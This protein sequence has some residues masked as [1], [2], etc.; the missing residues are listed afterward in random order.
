LLFA[1][2]RRLVPSD[3]FPL[4]RY[5]FVALAALAFLLAGSLLVGLLSK[6]LFLG[7]S[8]GLF[9]IIAWYLVL[10]PGDR[11]R[12]RARV[13]AVTWRGDSIT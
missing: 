4:A 5:T 10:T 9:L 12:I 7:C 13:E 1:W 11:S 8:L 6:M 3:R 2:V